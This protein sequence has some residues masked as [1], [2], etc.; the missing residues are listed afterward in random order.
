MTPPILPKMV[1]VRQI[2]GLVLVDPTDEAAALLFESQF[3]R[4]FRM[5]SGGRPC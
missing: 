4:M 5:A 2:A 1:G 3:R